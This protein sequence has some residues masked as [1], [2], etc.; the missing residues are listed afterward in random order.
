MSNGAPGIVGCTFRTEDTRLTSERAPVYNNART[1]YGHTFLEGLAPIVERPS[2]LRPPLY[3]WGFC[4]YGLSVSRLA[5]RIVEVHAQIEE[6]I[7]DK[8]W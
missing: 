6:K 1:E 2:P 3:G 7:L 5:R 4:V 8:L